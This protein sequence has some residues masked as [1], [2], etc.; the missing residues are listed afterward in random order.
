MGIKYSRITVVRDSFTIDDFLNLYQD[1][2]NKKDIYMYIRE[3]IYSRIKINEL[4]CFCE[5]APIHLN[6]DIPNIK[7][8]A[9]IYKLIFKF[10]TSEL[11]PIN[12]P[13][14]LERRLIDLSKEIGKQEET[15]E[16]SNFDEV[17]QEWYSYLLP[18]T[19]PV[20]TKYWR[21]RRGP[22]NPVS[23][24]LRRSGML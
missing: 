18:R 21:E 3:P 23:S 24:S 8:Q 13:K 4:L 15:D 2:E 10:I 1:E 17:I 22:N 11:L 14:R 19:I 20:M 12:V 16:I 5:L 6:S 9:L 7:K